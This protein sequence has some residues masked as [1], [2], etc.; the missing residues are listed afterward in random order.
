[1]NSDWPTFYAYYNLIV[2]LAIELDLIYMAPSALQAQIDSVVV[3]FQNHYAFHMVMATQTGACPF[4]E[5][6]CHTC[7]NQPGI[8]RD[9]AN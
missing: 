1:M 6:K 5:D 2:E 3:V 4:L 7:G 8:V 9:A